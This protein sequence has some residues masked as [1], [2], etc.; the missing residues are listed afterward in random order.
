M[1]K[2]KLHKT[3]KLN[4]AAGLG[5]H[6]RSGNALVEK[7]WSAVYLFQSRE[8][9]ERAC[10]PP[11]QFFYIPN[12]YLTCCQCFKICIFSH[13]MQKNPFMSLREE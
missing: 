9:T 10:N 8:K 1:S 3:V 4:Q 2:D 7:K 5:P 6:V 13:A 12:P 11:N